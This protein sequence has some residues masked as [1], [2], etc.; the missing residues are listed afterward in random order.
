MKSHIEWLASYLCGGRER[1]TIIFFNRKNLALR[2]IIHNRLNTDYLKQLSL[3]SKLLGFLKI[4]V[5]LCLLC[6]SPFIQ[7]GYRKT[8]LEGYFAKNTNTLFSIKSWSQYNSR[9]KISRCKGITWYKRFSS[10]CF[11]SC[12]FSL[13]VI[14]LLT[15][16][17][18]P[19]C[20]PSVPLPPYSHPVFLL[21]WWLNNFLPLFLCNTLIVYTITHFVYVDDK[22]SK[23]F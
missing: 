7:G 15:L 4:Y 21:H 12:L 14:Q 6:S 23:I 1:Q 18:L 13:L 20:P 11:R 8:V 17:H 9:R 16:A 22:L 5:M 19:I 10:L 3:P 2:N